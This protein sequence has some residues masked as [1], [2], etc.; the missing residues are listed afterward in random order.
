[1]VGL[2]PAPTEMEDE[3]LQPKD[4]PKE[5]N[6]NTKEDPR[7]THISGLLKEELKKEIIILLRDFRD[8]FAWDYTNMP[9]LSSSLVEHCLAIKLDYRPYQHP[10]TRNVER[11]RIESK[12]NR[13]IIKRRIY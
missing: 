4:L 7:V 8:C 6:L 3:R 10:P 11:G 12:T 13:K 2:S 9:G 1:M 5:I